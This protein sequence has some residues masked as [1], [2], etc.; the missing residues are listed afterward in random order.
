MLSFHA[1][2]AYQMFCGVLKERT[3]LFS[4]KII[5]LTCGILYLTYI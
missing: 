1:V 3:N 2:F 4:G 5:L